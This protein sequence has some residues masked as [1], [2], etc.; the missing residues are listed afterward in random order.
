MKQPRKPPK[1]S[2]RRKR[3]LKRLLRTQGDPLTTQ[4]LLVA[5][6][7]RAVYEKKKRKEKGKRGKANARAARKRRIERNK[8]IVT[9]AR[10]KPC[11]DCN[12]FWGAERME[13]DHVPER[14]EKTDAISTLVKCSTARLLREIAICDVVCCACH[15]KRERARGRTHGGDPRPC[16]NER[17]P[18][19]CLWQSE[20][21]TP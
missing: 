9:A 12:L 20:A 17:L 11:A 1:L 18:G 21:P 6:A 8:P 5:L 15:D 4:R 7:F 14:G 10:S 19:G 2:P 16:P 13:F 3:L